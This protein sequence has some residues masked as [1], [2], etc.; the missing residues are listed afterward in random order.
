MNN[1]V[2]YD[3]HAAI[4]P[5]GRAERINILRHRTFKTIYDHLDDH[6]EW[7]WVLVSFVGETTIHILD[8]WKT[9]AT[10]TF[11]YVEAYIEPPPFEDVDHAIGY[12]ALHLC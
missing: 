11:P 3:V 12:I 7:R 9:S 2:C 1:L 5:D 6:D 8:L 10:D 4:R